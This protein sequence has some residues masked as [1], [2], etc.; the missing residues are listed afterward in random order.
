MCSK[1]RVLILGLDGASWD[2]INPLLRKGQL[3]AFE[4]LVEDGLHSE[5]VS[6]QPPYTF[7]AWTTLLTGKNPGK[8]GIFNFTEKIPGTYQLRF[9]NSTFRRS[10]SI[11]QILSRHGLRVGVMGI[12]ATYPP[13]DINGFMISGFDSPVSRNI[14]SSFV[15]PS[16]LYNDLK[17]ISADYKI[18][19]L[20]EN[21]MDEKWYYNARNKIFNSLDIK[22][23]TAM[24]LYR[25]EP[26]DCFMVMF[27]ETDTACHHFWKFYD[28][29]SPRHEKTG[30][31]IL[32]DVIP[33]I[34]KKIDQIIKKF[35]DNT[36]DN[37]TILIVSDHGFGGVSDKAVS[38]NKWLQQQG[39]LQLAAHNSAFDTALTMMRNTGLKYLPHSI[40][41][42]VF[43]SPL[44]ML[45]QR[46]ESSSRFKGI[47]WDK[48]MAFSED[49]SCFPGIY[50]NLKGR[51]PR[52]T[53][54]EPD[55]YHNIR[56]EII[57]KILK[58]TD[59]ET[60]SRVV[61]NAWKREDLYNGD[62]VH[63]APDI[64]I[65]F[66]TSSAYSYLCL[67]HNHFRGD[68]T[69]KKIPT[70]N[71]CGSR[72]FSMSGSHRQDGV[73]LCSGNMLSKTRNLSAKPSLQDITPTILSFFGIPVDRDMDG[74]VL[75][76][77]KDF[78]NFIILC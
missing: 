59:P 30:N 54:N 69:L 66:N 52:G 3:P 48:T 6:T 14:D 25:R 44:K 71:L 38:I 26:W 55:E 4:S 15:R 21:F 63:L 13:E 8:H 62:H 34:Y 24:E 57:S 32:H 31:N 60:N 17:T 61:K 64:M 10:E 9:L 51:E 56:E 36:W 2:I 50:I 1:N 18:S 20:L 77:F 46:M 68:E 5:L 73:F 12:P 70:E 65:E 41:E 33:D 39:F 49:L 37:T 78:F 16:R 7:P 74:K 76:I 11:W 75:D 42:K 45:A 58:W 43:R 22:A 29:M 40:Q 53:V 28:H 72:L 35:L 19:N 67:P 27:G 23:R 47:V